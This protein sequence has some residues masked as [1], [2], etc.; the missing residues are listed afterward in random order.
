VEP[1]GVRIGITDH[2]QSELGD[3][4]YLELPEVGRDLRQDDVFGS[5]ESV[6][7]VSDLICPVSGG[8][9]AVNE[10]LIDHPEVINRD[11]YGEG[12]MLVLKLT[13]PAELAGLLSAAEY[14]RFLE[15]SP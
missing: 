11:P 7:A 4:V 5:V 8:V 15:A 10:D 14:E 9:V 13:D 12:W 1:N 2:A 6:K 3:I